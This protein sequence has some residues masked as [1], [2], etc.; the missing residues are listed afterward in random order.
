LLVDHAMQSIRAGDDRETAIYNAGVARLRPI[1]M[2]TIA[3]IAGILPVALG[4]GE[5]SKFRSSMGIAII[6][7]LVISTAITLIVVPAIFEYIDRMR[8]FI[9]SRIGHP[10]E[11]NLIEETL[12]VAKSKKR[13]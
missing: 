1:L 2:T 13:K 7:G 3:M 6:G 10:D 4:F 9:E 5:V 11:P 8:V 12:Q